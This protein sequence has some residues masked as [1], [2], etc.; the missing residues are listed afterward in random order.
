[1]VLHYI[2]YSRY[3]L[4]DQKKGGRTPKAK[5]TAQERDKNDIAERHNEQR[6]GME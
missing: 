3:K 6:F 2:N 1:M 5:T 4:R